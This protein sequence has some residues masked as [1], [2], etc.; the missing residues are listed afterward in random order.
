[1]NILKIERILNV[2]DT[3]EKWAATSIIKKR[4]FKIV[5]YAVPFVGVTSLS[6]GALMYNTP[7]YVPHL[8]LIAVS[9]M[10]ALGGCAI[11][12]PGDITAHMIAYRQSKRLTPDIKLGHQML[13]DPTHKHKQR[14]EKRNAVVK[15]MKDNGVS[16]QLLK[17]LVGKEEYPY[18]FWEYCWKALS[19]S[20]S[21]QN[22]WEQM[23]V[24][25]E[26]SQTYKNEAGKHL[27]I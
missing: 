9:L 25:V 19:S 8:Y 2:C 12:R 16:S 24:E 20:N 6:W 3:Y 5:S 27:K 7:L 13:G 1:M 26:Q 4:W 21:I 11:M 17:R 10:I 14:D 22:E 23:L 18:D 15:L